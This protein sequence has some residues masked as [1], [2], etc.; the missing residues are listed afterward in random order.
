MAIS[1]K[2]KDSVTGIVLY[3]FNLIRQYKDIEEPVALSDL[4]DYL[5]AFNKS[6]TAIR[7]GLSRMTKADVIKKIKEKG[8]I[9]YKLDKDGK[10]D[11]KIWS[12]GYEYFILKYSYRDSGDWDH[13][14]HSY[15]LKDFNKSDKAN[16]VII[17]NLEELGKVEIEYNIW[18]S[19]YDMSEKIIHLLDGNNISYFNT[20]GKIN[21]NIDIIN[22]LKEVYNLAKLK[23]G[24]QEILKMIE[25]NN[26]SI[27]KRDI[28][29]VELLPK[30]GYTGWLFYTL[31][32]EDPFLPRDII[33]EWIGDKA[34]EEFKKFR[35]KTFNK[36][37]NDLFKN[38]KGV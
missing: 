23:R 12:R 26:E 17:E 13:N 4:I 10:E 8:E 1:I 7:M 38:R 5:K 14:W 3:I 36:I 24:Y 25:E 11:L 6:E 21:T 29:T 18:T 15:I 33:G 34:V 22:Y 16:K 27:E 30:L 19:P 31:V 2:H 28:K 20:I 37:I 9:Y 35:E 32:T